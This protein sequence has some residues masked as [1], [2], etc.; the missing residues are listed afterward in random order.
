MPLPGSDPTWDS[1]GTNTTAVASIHKTDGFGSNEVPTSRELNEWMKIV[2]ENLNALIS[3]SSPHTEIIPAFNGGGVG[4]LIGPGVPLPAVPHNTIEIPEIPLFGLRV[5]SKITEIRTR[6]IEG[7]SAGIP[8]WVAVTTYAAGTFPSGNRV[9]NGGKVYVCTQSGTSAGSGGPTGTGTGIVDGTCHW[10]FVCNIGDPGDGPLGV[11][12]TS[13]VDGGGT[14]IAYVQG[15]NHTDSLPYGIDLTGLDI[16]VAS[17]T[18][19]RLH[20]VNT[21]CADT[22]TLNNA[23]MDITPLP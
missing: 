1:N 13:W 8:A 2:G 4:G 12:V 20:F 22:T 5:G 11:M 21:G 16:T 7:G 6:V 14:L 9:K 3:L 17:G 15:N 19:Y 18:E 10:D 23:E